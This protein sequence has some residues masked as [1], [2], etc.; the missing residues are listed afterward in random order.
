M[1][2]LQSQNFFVR[3]SLDVIAFF[4]FCAVSLVVVVRT[5][6]GKF[7]KATRGKKGKRE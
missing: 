7:R 6:V 1:T 3:H 5:I 2:K 4:I